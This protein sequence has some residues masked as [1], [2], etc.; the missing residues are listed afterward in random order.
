MYHYKKKYM[1]DLRNELGAILGTRWTPEMVHG[2]GKADRTG[3]RKYYDFP[4]AV[5][6][7]PKLGKGLKEMVPK[8]IKSGAYKGEV[9]FEEVFNTNLIR[10]HQRKNLLAKAQK[11]MDA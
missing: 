2:S 11:I 10:E 6:M 9:E 5:L 8:P 7:N 3:T 1:D 4:L